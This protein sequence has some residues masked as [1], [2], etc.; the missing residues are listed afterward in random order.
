MNINALNAHGACA[1]FDVGDTITR[2]PI[3]K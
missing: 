3:W 2:T 1:Y